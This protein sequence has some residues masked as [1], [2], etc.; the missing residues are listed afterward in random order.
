MAIQSVSEFEAVLSQTL[1]NIDKV[2]YERGEPP[3]LKDARRTMQIVLDSAQDKAKLKAMKER[4]SAA[5]EVVRLEIPDN[6]KLHE[7][8]WDLVDFLDFGI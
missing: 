2:I 5:V 6:E 8:L 4:L 7:S 1:F 3:K